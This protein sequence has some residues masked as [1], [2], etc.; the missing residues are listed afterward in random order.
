MLES[1][2]AAAVLAHI[3]S[4]PPIDGDASLVLH[5]SLLSHLAFLL[6]PARGFPLF[7]ALLKADLARDIW[8]SNLDKMDR[9][10][11]LGERVEKTDFIAWLDA[12]S[13]DPETPQDAEAVLASCGGGLQDG[14]PN[15]QKL[16]FLIA[17]RRSYAALNPFHADSHR[18]GRAARLAVL[19]RLGV[20]VC[21]TDDGKTAL[22]LTAKLEDAASIRYLAAAGGAALIEARDRNGETALFGPASRKTA[23]ATVRLLVEL[24]VEVDAIAGNGRTALFTAAYGGSADV[25]AALID[26]GADPNA[27]TGAG[28]TVLEM[29]ARSDNR[30][31][32]KMLLEKGAQPCKAALST[33]EDSMHLEL[34][35]MLRDALGMERKTLDLADFAKQLAVRAASEAE[36]SGD[37]YEYCREDTPAAAAALIAEQYWEA[38]FEDLARDAIKQNASSE[39]G[40]AKMADIF[41]DI[42]AQTLVGEPADSSEAPET[43]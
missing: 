19:R 20:D 33:A 13:S 36:D 26:L 5:S 8:D 31:T 25:V 34:A 38:Q 40:L 16:W 32:V 4:L 11:V 29:A 18:A 9:D 24:G 41:H 10:R 7:W 37:F 15:L 30:A 6:P 42:V 22:H 3:A 1:N 14:D 39:D 27:T 21:S 17:G 23:A 35:A 12:L 2:D 28:G 43:S